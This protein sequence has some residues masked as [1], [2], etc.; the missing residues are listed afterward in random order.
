MPM[1]FN[2]LFSIFSNKNKISSLQDI[3]KQGRIIWYQL[4]HQLP[5]AY[6][7][8][9]KDAVRL[10]KFSELVQ[11]LNLQ[12]K[13]ALKYWLEK[14]VIRFEIAPKNEYH[15]EKER[16]LKWVQIYSSHLDVLNSKTP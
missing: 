2:F 4:E 1:I 11:T 3:E 7:S 13:Q 6:G 9:A 16:R 15:R 8:L 12:Q 14:L 5:Y 10:Q